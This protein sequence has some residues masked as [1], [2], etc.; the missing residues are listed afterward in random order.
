MP[1][2]SLRLSVEYL[3]AH[4]DTNFRNFPRLRHVAI[5]VVGKDDIGV[6]SQPPIDDAITHLRLAEGWRWWHLKLDQFPH[7]PA[8]PNLV[9]LTTLD[10]PVD[11]TFPLPLSLRDLYLGDPVPGANGDPL[12]RLT[13]LT[14]L[15]LECRGQG[16]GPHE[17]LTVLTTLQRL[18]IEASPAVIPLVG[19]LSLLTHLRFDRAG[20]VDQGLALDLTP[21]TRLNNLVHLEFGR[22]GS[23]L[24]REHFQAIEAISSLRSLHLEVMQESQLPGLPFVFLTPITR[25]V[26]R[27]FNQSKSFLSGFQTEGLQDLSLERMHELGPEGVVALGRATGLTHLQLSYHKRGAAVWPGQ[28]GLALM[29]MSRLRALSRA[30]ESSELPARTCV[31]AIGL[32]RQLTSLKWAGKYVTNVDVQTSL[33]LRKLRV[34]SILSQIP[35]PYDPIGADTVFALARLPELRKLSMKGKFGSRPFGLTDEVQTLVNGER[36]NKG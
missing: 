34:L 8:L 11:S 25:L 18:S 26:L 16:Q 2:L 5:A 7:L 19:D 12:T 13:N 6:L 30:L 32:L 36:H 24:T 31:K 22:V 4:P 1:F 28:V 23:K 10:Y 20:M 3:R 33:G 17:A 21:L 35:E 27:S 29:Q 9:G 14:S 15:R